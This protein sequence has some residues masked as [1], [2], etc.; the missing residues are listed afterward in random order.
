MRKQAKDLLYCSR[1]QITVN[2]PFLILLL[3]AT[4]R[5]V[6]YNHIVFYKPILQPL[7]RERSDTEYG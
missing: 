5:R 7:K 1:A 2:G 6:A 3:R 4:S